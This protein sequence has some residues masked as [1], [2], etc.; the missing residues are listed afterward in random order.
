MEQSLELPVGLKFDP[1]ASRLLEDSFMDQ[2]FGGLSRL[3]HTFRLEDITTLLGHHDATI[4]QPRKKP[5]NKI[6]QSD[7]VQQQEIL[8]EQLNNQLK[9]YH[10]RCICLSSS[11]EELNKL[12]LSDKKSSDLNK[13]HSKKKSIRGSHGGNG[14]QSVEESEGWS[15]PD[16]SVSLAR[17]SC[18][19]QEDSTVQVLTREK[20]RLHSLL[21]ESNTRIVQLQ[22]DLESTISQYTI[23]ITEQEGEISVLTKT[24]KEIKADSRESAAKNQKEIERLEMEKSLLKQEV[25][26]SDSRLLEMTKVMEEEQRQRLELADWQEQQL[27][28]GDAGLEVLGEEEGVGQGAGLELQRC[29]S[30]DQGIDSDRLSSL[31]HSQP[32]SLSKYLMNLSVYVF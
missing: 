8:I 12:I 20:Q 24:I 5:E 16:R 2:S 22:K 1:S 29:A 19:S 21:E 32:M 27:A 25:E 14:E 30:P 7:I 17:M 10:T 11:T 28:A 13:L 26:K 3:S 6:S 31:E 15:E 18:P 9:N 23:K 4:P